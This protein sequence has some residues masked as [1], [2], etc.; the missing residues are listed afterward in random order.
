[1]SNPHVRP[2][3]C[4]IF[5]CASRAAYVLLRDE[6]LFRVDSA[7]NCASDTSDTERTTIAA[8][9]SMSENP[10]SLLQ[11]DF[12]KAIHRDRLVHRGAVSDVVHLQRHACATDRNG[13]AHRVRA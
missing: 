13:R 8:S 2:R 11:R 7:N 3:S 10:D 4:S 6:K 1:M 12:A 5:C 9:T